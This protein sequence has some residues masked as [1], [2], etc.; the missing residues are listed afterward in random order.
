MY[1]KKRLTTIWSSPVNL[2][3]AAADYDFKLP[4]GALFYPEEAGVVITT[5]GTPTALVQPTVRFGLGEGTGDEADLLAA[6]LATN[7]DAA[8][9]RQRYTS[10]LLSYGYSLLSFGVTVPG[11]GIDTLAGVAYVRGILR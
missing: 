10:L 3:A 2:L 6:V 5:F 7:L 11:S 4:P 1:A 9:A 8:N